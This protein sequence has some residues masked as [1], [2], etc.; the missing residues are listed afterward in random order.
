[1]SCVSFG[2]LLSSL[3][4]SFGGRLRLH[5]LWHMIDFWEHVIHTTSRRPATPVSGWD[6]AFPIYHYPNSKIVIVLSSSICT[7]SRPREHSDCQPSSRQPFRELPNGYCKRSPSPSPSL[8]YDGLLLSP[9][10]SSSSSSDDASDYAVS[11]LLQTGPTTTSQPGFPTYEQYKRIEAVY[12]ANLAP[13]KRAKALITQ[14]LFDQIWEVLWQPEATR[15]GTPQFRFWVRKMFRLVNFQGKDGG[16]GNRVGREWQRASYGDDTENGTINSKGKDVRMKGEELPPVVVHENRP[17][18]IMEQM[19][20]VLC[21]CH[22]LAQHGGR[23]KT[24][25][26]VREHY[27]WVPKELVAQFVKACPTCSIKRTGIQGLMVTREMA[28]G[29]V[30]KEEEEEKTNAG[31]SLRGLGSVGRPTMGPTEPSNS[32]IPKAT[33]ILHRSNDENMPP[34]AGASICNMRGDNPFTLSARQPKPADST[35]KNDTGLLEIKCPIPRSLHAVPQFHTPSAAT[36]PLNTLRYFGNLT[37]GTNNIWNSAGLPP[38]REALMNSATPNNR[39]CALRKPAFL[40]NDDADE[41]LP[42]TLQRLLIKRPVVTHHREDEPAPVPTR[43][44]VDPA[45]LSSSSCS[46]MDLELPTNGA[47]SEITPPLRTSTPVVR[48]L[49]ANRRH[50]M[51]IPSAGP[52]IPEPWNWIHR[53]DNGVW[54]ME[55]PILPGPD[56]IDIP[57]PYPLPWLDVIVDGSLNLFFPPLL[58]FRDCYSLPYS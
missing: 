21:Y 45:M 52:A 16:E 33:S 54:L 47:N 8:Y 46:R 5:K 49:H 1:M 28:S 22:G 56:D 14:A 18:A 10:P 37:S 23:D 42:P 51:N 31:N 43:L 4:S 11:P 38:L 30:L 29:G 53:D 7:M 57:S 35:Q 58:G 32:S 20:E 44:C 24:C 27:S 6:T 48:G 26:I 19:Y 34:A 41:S 9:A 40:D 15:V 2:Y 50:T 36:R 39:S 25:G 3:L 12:F 13:R 17:V 55:P